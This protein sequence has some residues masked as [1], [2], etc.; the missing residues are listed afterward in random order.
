MTVDDGDRPARPLAVGVTAD[1]GRCVAADD[2]DD[3]RV[4]ADDAE[5]GHVAA[6]DAD[7]ANEERP[8][9]PLAIGVIVDDRVA[10]PSRRGVDG[11]A[12][13]LMDDVNDVWQR[14]V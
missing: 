12:T 13:N 1:D 11:A 7:D 6:Y 5:Y 9:R 3:G 2:V 10:I 14:V 8:A 4:A